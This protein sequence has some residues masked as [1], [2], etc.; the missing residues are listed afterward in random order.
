[1]KDYYKIL[2]L[3]KSASTDEVK[4]VYRRLAMKYHPDRNNAAD[5]EAKFKEI[6]EAY[7]TLSNSEKR[8]KYNAKLN[9]DK[10]YDPFDACFNKKNKYKEQSFHNTSPNSKIIVTATLKQAYNG[11]NAY[12]GNRIYEIKPGAW[13][14]QTFIIQNHILEI[15][16][17]PDPIFKRSD[18]DLLVDVN[19]DVFHA[20]LGSKLIINHL[21]DNQLITKIPA[22]IQNGKVIRLTLAGMPFYSHSF[23]KGDLLIRVNIVMP[24]PLN[25]IQKIILSVLKIRK[26]IT[27]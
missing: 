2:G 23:L 16:I 6:N 15:K 9:F 25:F 12:I 5:A 14:G 26:P 13:S 10:N 20:M 18:N 27:I 22:G 3:D 24:K 11:F 1:M 19:I 7:E 17:I 4:H 8:E 21:D